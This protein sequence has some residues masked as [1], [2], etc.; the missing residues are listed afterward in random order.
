MNREEPIIRTQFLAITASLIAVVCVAACQPSETSFESSEPVSGTA[1]AN[2]VDLY[3]QIYGEGTPLILLHGGLGHSGHWTNQLSVLS[4]HY[5]VI[6]VDSRGHGRST[7][8]EQQI[9]YALMAS[10]IVA[11]MDYLEIER[12]HILGWSD[13]GNIGLYL[14]IHHPDRLIKVVASGA[15][16]NPSGVRSDVGENQKFLSYVGDAVEDYQTLSPDPAN[17]DAFFGNIGQMWA[18][19][20]DFTV[21]QLGSIA[22]P[23]LLLDGES[24]EAIYTAHTREMAGMIP[25]AKLTFVPGTGHFGMWEKPEEIN[26]AI[27]DFLKL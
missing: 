6:T 15:N 22:V 5:K 23:I 16:Y 9:S 18:S 3:Y 20:P 13:G 4:E 27:L 21:E 17:W 10:D 11:L 7:M 26:S 8:T 12:A 2:G 24:D 19:E 1:P 25:T 14:A